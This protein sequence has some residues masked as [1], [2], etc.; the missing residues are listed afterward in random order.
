[1]GSWNTDRALAVVGI[2]IGLLGLIPIFRESSNQLRVSYVAALA[3][4]FAVFYVLYKSGRGP[5]YSTT[6]MKKHLRFVTNDGTR[7]TF[8]REQT[9][10]IN[11]GCMDEIWCRNIVADG[12]I[13]NVQVDGQTPLQED[14][15]HLGCL[16][17]VRKRF[18]GTLYKGQTAT[19]CWSHD[20]VDSF[21]DRREFIDHDVTPATKLLDLTV[22]LPAGQRKFSKVKLEERVAGEPSRNLEAPAVEQNGT[23]IRAKIKS[24]HPG[25]TIRLSWEW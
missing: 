10:M 8:T 19:V 21:P 17:D 13:Q 6:S 5:Q 18:G 3:L 14:Q 4:L 20:L 16:L 25:R 1:M 22:E 7:A 15:Q 23:I 9:I 12:S 2:V 11:F 24:P